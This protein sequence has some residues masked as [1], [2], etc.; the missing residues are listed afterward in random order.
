MILDGSFHNSVLTK[1]EEGAES[2]ELAKTER[3]VELEKALKFEKDK[4]KM[5]SFL[6]YTTFTTANWI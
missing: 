2:L 4:F 1:K 3:I 6:E 5:V